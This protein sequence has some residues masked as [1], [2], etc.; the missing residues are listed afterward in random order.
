[1]KTKLFLAAAAVVFSVSMISCG[2]KKAAEAPAEE[3][4]VCDS[5]KKE[6]CESADSVACDSLKKACCSEEKEAC[7]KEEKKSCCKGEK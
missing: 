4:Q 6:C 5:L 3:V 2:N 1:M 7:N